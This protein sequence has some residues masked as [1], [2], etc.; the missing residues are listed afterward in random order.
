MAMTM[1]HQAGRHLGGGLSFDSMPYTSSP[2]FN[3]PWGAGSPNTHMYPQSMSS[4]NMGFD[5]I[6]K[7]AQKNTT[8]SLP[9]PSVSASAPMGTTGGFSGTQYDSSQLVNMSTS[10]W[11][12]PHET[13]HIRVEEYGVT[14]VDHQVGSG[15]R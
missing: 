4:N 1:D 13:P 11:P 9:Y 6:A 2:Q 10:R 14:L 3:N 8:T 5:A 15:L 12:K 7:Q